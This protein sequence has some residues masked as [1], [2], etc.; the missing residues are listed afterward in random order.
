MHAMHTLCALD[1]RCEWHL[2]CS[3]VFCFVWRVCPQVTEVQAWALDRVTFKKIL[4]DTA[5]KQQ[6]L[7]RH[8]LEGVRGRDHCTNALKHVGK[9]ERKKR[10]TEGVESGGR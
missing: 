9:K 2:V 8:F 7:Y 6:D 1:H 3:S 10:A 5:Q 4:Q